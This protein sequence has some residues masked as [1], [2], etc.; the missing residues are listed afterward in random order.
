MIDA[1]VVP[2]FYVVG[3]PMRFVLQEGWSYKSSH[4]IYIFGT[5]SAR[6]F[7][8]KLHSNTTSHNPDD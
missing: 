8:V 1:S 4:A 7:R 6:I 2:F 5:I 3:N